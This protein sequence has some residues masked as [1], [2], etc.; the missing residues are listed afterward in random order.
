MTKYPVPLVRLKRHKSQSTFHT[1]HNVSMRVKN[2][3]N[4][5]FYTREIET[6]KHDYSENFKFFIYR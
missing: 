5:S 3:Q 1:F 2:F 6:I 4:G